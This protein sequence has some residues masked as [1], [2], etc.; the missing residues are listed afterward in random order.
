MQLQPTRTLRFPQTSVFSLLT[1]LMVLTIC[2]NLIKTVGCLEQP[3][4]ANVVDLP[5][6]AISILASHGSRHK[7]NLA[8]Y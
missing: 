5:A 2:S 8:N 4:L 7:P 6:A 1:A 3:V